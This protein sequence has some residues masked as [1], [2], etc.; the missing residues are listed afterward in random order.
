MGGT[1]TLPWIHFSCLLT[2]GTGGDKKARPLVP[3]IKCRL[4]QAAEKNATGWVATWE[5]DKS[6]EAWLRVTSFFL[7]SIKKIM[8][9]SLVFDGACRRGSCINHWGEAGP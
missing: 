3:V 7:Q 4:P 9:M 1:L 2:R 8:L 5:A 6:Q